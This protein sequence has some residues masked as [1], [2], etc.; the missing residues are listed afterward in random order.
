M[1]LTVS[2][3]VSPV[4]TKLVVQTSAGATPDN[5][6]LGGAG[7]VY[8]I[9]VDNAANA[10]ACYLKLYDDGNPS[11]GT[12]HPNAIFRVPTGQ[13]R[14]WVIVEGMDFTILSFACVTQPGTTGTVSPTSP[15]VVRMACA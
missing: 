13:R 7:K 12:T 4:A 9:D 8:M 2:T 14:S 3:Q 6:V 5:N 15:V 11:V 1:A 10:A